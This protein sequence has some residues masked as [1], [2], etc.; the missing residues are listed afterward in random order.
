MMT[1]LGFVL[2]LA[3]A[4]AVFCLPR[5]TAAVGI[6]SA[7][8]YL[9]EERPLEIGGFHFTAIRFVLLVG[10]IRVMSRGELS[11]L[12]FNKV[13]RSLFTF[14]AAVLVI[15]VVRH[16]TLTDVIY[17]A[18]V[19]YN[20][21]LSYIVFRCLLRSERD[22]RE[23]LSKLAFIII[24][25]VLLMLLES[26]TNRN[27]FAQL[28]G[29]TDTDLI[30]DGHVRAQGPFRSPITAGGFGATFAMLYASVLFAR[31]RAR[32]ALVG[33]IGSTIIVLCSHSSGPLLGLALG[34][35]ALACWYARRHT[36]KIRWGIVAVL[37]G[38]NMVMKVPVWFLIGR[39]SDVVGGG[40]YYRAYLI[41]QFV[42]HFGS[43]WLLGTSDTSDWM[44]TQLEFGGTDLTNKFVSDG[45]NG[46][47]IGLI[48]SVV[49]VVVCFKWIGLALKA[50]RGRPETEKLIWGI[51]AT[52]VG[53]ITIFFSVTYFDQSYVLWY[54]LLAY[55]AGLETRKKRRL[56]GRFMS[57][58][59]RPRDIVGAIA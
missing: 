34:I 25:F 5:G 7:V 56:A 16:E 35:V 27:F 2:T 36:S 49:L 58:S 26:Y 50:S 37:L 29:F 46:G 47:L 30:R 44:P 28:F 43:W 19:L 55:I 39:I 51:G 17:Q 31:P 6:V 48:L 53:T 38:L 9:T 52:L 14:G 11:W 8:C 24:P 22:L 33:V 42:K 59:N 32:F 40:G 21:S 12:R 3:F 15:S 57:M 41:D 54:F 23:V 10:M 13:D 1:P 18:G 20:V 45:V 4:L